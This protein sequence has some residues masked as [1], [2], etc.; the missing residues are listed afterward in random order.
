MICE[1]KKVLEFDTYLLKSK[2]G[3]YKQMIELYGLDK[4]NV[5][6]RIKIDKRLLSQT[7]Q[8]YTQPYAFELVDNAQV[9]LINKNNEAEYIG[10]EKG[11][12]KY[13]L[14]RVYG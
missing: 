11:D 14:K 5:G 3:E 10:V 4:L 9:K 2:S 7:S 13:L 8:S 12:K 6:D 1:I